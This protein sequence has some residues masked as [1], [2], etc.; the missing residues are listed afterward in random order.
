MDELYSESNNEI[1]VELTTGLTN[2]IT[3]INDYSSTNHLLIS[4][5][6]SNNVYTNLSINNYL[7]VKIE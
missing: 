1:I 3:R 7:V 6:M 5:L 4:K 2:V